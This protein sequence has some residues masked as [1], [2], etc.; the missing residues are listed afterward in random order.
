MLLFKINKLNKLIK[1]IIAN[2]QN[3]ALSKVIL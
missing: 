2:L 1:N 3:K